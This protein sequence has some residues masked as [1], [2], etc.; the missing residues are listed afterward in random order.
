MLADE[1][2]SAIAYEAQRAY[3]DVIRNPWVDPPWTAIE[4]WYR[5]A[6]VHGVQGVLAGLTPRQL[7]ERWHAY[8]TRLGWHYG[9]V[10]DPAAKTH[11]NLVDWDLLPPAQQAKDVLFRE[12]VLMLDRIRVALAAPGQ[13][14]GV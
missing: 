8:Y 7:H 4:Q 3:N 9:T 11:P 12:H 2:I 10:R 1:A 5:R 13:S 6:Y 14:H